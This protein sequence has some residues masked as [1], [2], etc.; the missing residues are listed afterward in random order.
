VGE[1]GGRKGHD[2]MMPESLDS[3]LAEQAAY[4]R[5]VAAKYEG[6]SLP[7]PGGEE[8]IRALDEFR[9]AGRVLELACGPG[10]WTPQLL[11]HAD[12]VTAVDASPEMLAIAAERAPE[13][14]FIEADLFDWEPHDRWDVVFFGFWLSHVPLERFEDFWSL[15]DRCLEPDGRVFFADDGY[16]APEERISGEP[17]HTISRRLADGTTHRIQKIPHEPAELERRLGELGWAID[18]R[19]TAGPFYWGAG[20]RTP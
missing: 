8:L 1:G 16:I 2:L 6:H 4:Y 13:A 15:V 3:L 20:A 12:H 5:A 9:P 14:T 17:A 18:V 11:R 10:T 19:P 7:L